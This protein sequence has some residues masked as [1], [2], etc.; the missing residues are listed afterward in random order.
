[1][2]L[3]NHVKIMTDLTLRFNQANIN[4]STSSTG[5]FPLLPKFLF[6]QF[7]SSAVLGLRVSLPQ[8]YSNVIR[9]DH[10]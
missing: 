5:L 10:I 6:V 7:F 3:T 9:M 1:M 2:T 4:E 8:A